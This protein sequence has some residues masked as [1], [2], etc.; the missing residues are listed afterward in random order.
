MPEPEDK[1]VEEIEQTEK[2]RTSR[3]IDTAEEFDLFFD[4]TYDE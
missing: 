1:K 2:D 4:A 3:F